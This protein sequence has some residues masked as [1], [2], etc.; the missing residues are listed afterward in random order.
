MNAKDRKIECMYM[1]I[2]E[3]FYVQV[4]RENNALKD[5]SISSML[6]VSMVDNVGDIINSTQDKFSKVLGWSK[7]HLITEE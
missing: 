3:K 2:L 4:V 7:D 6:D 5:R 1:E